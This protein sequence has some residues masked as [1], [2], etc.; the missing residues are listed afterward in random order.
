VEK[1]GW[2]E[3]GGEGGVGGSWWRRWGGWELV[4]KGWEG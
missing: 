3:A 2:E 4:E 1:V